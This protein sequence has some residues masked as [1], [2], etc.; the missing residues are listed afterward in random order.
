MIDAV[1]LSTI[2]ILIFGLV[3]MTIVVIT[4]AIA[5]AVVTHNKKTHL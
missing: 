2:H 4:L 1:L 3:S 5:L